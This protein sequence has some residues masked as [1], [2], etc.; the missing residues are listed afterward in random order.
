MPDELVIRGGMLVDGTGAAPR[1]ADV[2]IVDGRVAEIGAA[3]SGPRALDAS[4][5]FVAPGFVDIHTHYDAQVFWDPWLTP[6][7]LQGVTSVIA[8]HCGLS[9]AP[10]RETMRDSMMR[11]LHFVEDMAPD[12][13]REGVEW[14]WEDYGSYRSRVAERGVGINFGTYV[15]HTAVRLWVLGADAYTREAT[16][17]EIAA[18][19][20]VVADAIGHGAIGF[21]TDRSN[22]HRADGGTKVAS[23]FG[24]QAEVEALMR[25]AADAGGICAVIVDEDCSWLY[26]LQPQLGTRITWCQIITYPDGSPRQPWPE[27]QL[28]T[29]RELSLIHISEPTRP[30]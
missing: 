12:T 17:D 16:D 30:Y 23:Q 29:H 27:A 20:A 6:S 25:A 28:A 24:S 7:S 10:C 14:T 8:G 26:R 3:L 21:S 18:M 2:R 19:Q 11:T 22:F 9:I 13:L 1:R 15:G 4:G 5:A